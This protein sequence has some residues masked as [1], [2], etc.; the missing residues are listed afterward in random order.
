MFNTE[1]A[2][3]LSVLSE[4]IITRGRWKYTCSIDAM[5]GEFEMPP[6]KDWAFASAKVV[7]SRGHSF[8][9]STAFASAK[10][11]RC[12]SIFGSYENCVSKV[13]HNKHQSKQPTNRRS[14]G[15][16]L[17]SCS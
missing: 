15:D 10:M 4:S 8:Y 1:V 13:L 2:P 16:G 11:A 6:Q 14:F 5:E 17:I 9:K 3:A 7:N 12:M